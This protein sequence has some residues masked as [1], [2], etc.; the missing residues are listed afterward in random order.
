MLIM[1]TASRDQ[2]NAASFQ[3]PSMLL[4]QILA[5]VVKTRI[6]RK[7]RYVAH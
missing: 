1:M 3:R 5:P 6:A 4:P 7:M 2:Y